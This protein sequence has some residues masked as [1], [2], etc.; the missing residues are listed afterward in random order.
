MKANKKTVWIINNK[1]DKK[2]YLAIAINKMIQAVE[3]AISFSAKLP[4]DKF[5]DRHQ[6]D[7]E[8]SKALKIEAPEPHITIEYCA[9]D[10]NDTINIAHFI[11]DDF[12][13]IQITQVN[14]SP[15]LN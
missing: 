7:I 10:K 1:T 13:I 6:D 14:Q 12:E 9:T 3:M 2:L 11:S 8:P 15:P 4:K 5:P